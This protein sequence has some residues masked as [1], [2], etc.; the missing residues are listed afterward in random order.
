MRD[1]GKV[2]PIMTIDDDT[3]E[4]QKT[5][6]LSFEVE[7]FLNSNIG[8]YLI[9]RAEDQIAAAVEDL[10]LVDPENACRIRAIQQ[11]IHVAEDF[12]YWLAE[13]IQAGHNAAAAAL[14]KE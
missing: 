3:R 1:S 8:K 14:L 12:Q 5:I 2:P 7:A 13:A 10:K 9:K 11:I 6:E 4:L